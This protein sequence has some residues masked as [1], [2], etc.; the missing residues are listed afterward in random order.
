MFLTSQI[1]FLCRKRLQKLVISFNFFTPYI[2]ALVYM[3]M[4]ANVH[5]GLLRLDICYHAQKCRNRIEIFLAIIFY[6]SGEAQA[7]N[8]SEILTEFL[9][10]L[11]TCHVLRVV[12]TK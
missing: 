6:T 8:S 7:Q 12:T 2:V 3:C 10:L 5:I 4:H 9:L 1:Y 11:A